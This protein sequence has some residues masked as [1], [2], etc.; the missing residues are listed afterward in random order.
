MAQH[1]LYEVRIHRSHDEVH[2]VR[3]EDE[4]HARRSVLNGESQDVNIEIAPDKPR[5]EI[6]TSAWSVVEVL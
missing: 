2:K 4:A 5:D 3:A 1:K 6:D